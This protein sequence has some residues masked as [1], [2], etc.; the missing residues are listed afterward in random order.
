MVMFG[1]ANAPYEFCRLMNI[2]LGPLR[3]KICACYIDDVLVGASNRSVMFDHP[4]KIFNSHRN[5]KLTLKLGKCEFGLK[6][7]EFVEMK[8]SGEGLKPGDRKVEA[9]KEK[10]YRRRSKILLE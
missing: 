1:L 8:V 3:N 9:I 4:R 10:D 7:V 5:A 2:V 6:E